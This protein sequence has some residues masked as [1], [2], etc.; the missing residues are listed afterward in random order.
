MDI[1]K[2]L[3]LSTVVLYSSFS[4]AAII[5]L[6]LTGSWQASDY[7][8]S[9][10]LYG[11]DDLVFGTAASAGS[12]A[13]TLRVDTSSAVSYAAGYNN[14]GNILAHDWYGYS[15][16][17]LLGNPTFGDASWENADILTGLIGVDGLARALWTDA[18]IALGDPTRTS[19]RMF[20]DSTSGGTADIFFGSRT[21]TTIGNQFLMWEYFAGEEIRSQS[22]SASSSV[23]PEP[24]VFALLAVGLFG[25]GL[26][27]RK[28]A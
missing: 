7:D 8:V 25:L 28:Q 24:S 19:F 22:Y 2:K 10:T 18:D 6:T 20:G 21:N 13:V 26:S 15:D 9:S 1:L 12:F 17:T 11:D 5:D 14:G 16:V 23:V 4:Q 27:K 3:F